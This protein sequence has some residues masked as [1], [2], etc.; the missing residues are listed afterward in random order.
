MPFAHTTRMPRARKKPIVLLFDTG[1]PW[2]TDLESAVYETGQYRPVRLSELI[3]AIS[4]L[5]SG[6]AKALLVSGSRLSPSDELLLKEL[7]AAVPAALVLLF[8]TTATLA[9]LGGALDSGVTTVLPWPSNAESLVR[10]IFK[11]GG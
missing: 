3:D 10:A 6:V 1:V 4:F 7:R 9:S 11:P 2:A 8:T 5:R